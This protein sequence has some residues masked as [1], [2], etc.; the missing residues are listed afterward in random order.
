MGDVVNRIQLVNLLIRSRVNVP[1][2]EVRRAW[3]SDPQYMESE[4]L[5][6]GAIFLPGAGKDSAKLA[7]EAKQVQK[8]AKR[9]FE[10]AAKKYSKGPGASEGGHLGEFKRGT[11]APYFETALKGL[12]IG[13]VSEPVEGGGGLYIVKLIGIKSSGR[14]PFEEVKGPLSDKL[15]EKRLQER[16][17]KWATEDLRK[18]HHV[19]VMV[20]KLAL[21]AA[22]HASPSADA[23]PALAGAEKPPAMDKSAPP[24]ADQAAGKAASD[25]K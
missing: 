1:E 5:E 15:Y 7:E 18:E 2:E 10:S 19:D 22:D 12:G 21:I 14:R 25:R 16:F 6:V 17:Q 24:P 23:K 9:N 8:E 20:D 11:M 13:D 4:K 3:E